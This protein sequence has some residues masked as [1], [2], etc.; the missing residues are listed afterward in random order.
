MACNALTISD[1]SRGP[2]DRDLR[3]AEAPAVSGPS[4]HAGRG[5]ADIGLLYAEGAADRPVPDTMDTL[6]AAKR[7]PSPCER[8]SIVC[9]T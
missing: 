1:V 8:Y 6:F 4:R 3:L 7:S 9:A 5:M 2:S